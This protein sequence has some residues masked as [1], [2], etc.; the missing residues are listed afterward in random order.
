MFKL[1]YVVA[2]AEHFDDFFQLKSEHNSVYWSGFMTAPEPV[3]FKE[4]YSQELERTDRTIILLYIN[5]EIAGY[6]CIDNSRSYESVEISLGVRDKFTGNSL[7]KELIHFAT[8]YTQSNLPQ[9]KSLLA[10]ISVENYS[11]IK[12]FTRNEYIKSGAIELRK[13]QQKKEKVTFVEYIYNL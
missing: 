2:K 6:V 5:K 4:Y 12:S 11:S 10:W 1:N 13:F 7:G 3:K 8:N 9:V